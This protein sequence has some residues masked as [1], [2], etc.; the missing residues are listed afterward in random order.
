MIKKTYQLSLVGFLLFK[1]CCC[2][3]DN[4]GMQLNQKK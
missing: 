4:S 1:D 3:T 2:N